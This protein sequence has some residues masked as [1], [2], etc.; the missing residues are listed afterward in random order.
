MSSRSFL[1][2]AHR[3]A[4]RSVLGAGGD[5]VVNEGVPFN[6]QHIALMAAHLGV[7]GLDSACLQGR[8][9]ASVLCPYSKWLRKGRSLPGPWG[10]P[11][12]GWDPSLGRAPQ[13]LYSR[14]PDG[15]S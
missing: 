6:V 5:D 14:C 15:K 13:P 10:G 8:E 9:K 2:T 4:H 12:T 3:S 1:G 7:V 11:L